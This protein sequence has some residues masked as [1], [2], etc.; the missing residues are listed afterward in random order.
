MSRNPDLHKNHRSRTLETY[1]SQESETIPDHILLEMMLYYS[2]PRRDTNELAHALLEHCGS[3]N[4]VLDAT[5]KDLT[6]VKG[7]GS[8]SARRVRLFGLIK[9]KSDIHASLPP[10]KQFASIQQQNFKA[11]HKRR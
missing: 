5:E 2:I 4:N 11:F 7:I 8:N 1:L 6:E 9:R 3:F 10:K